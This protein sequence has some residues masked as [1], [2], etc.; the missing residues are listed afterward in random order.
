ME[1]IYKKEGIQ[2]I[3]C[4]GYN[5]PIICQRTNDGNELLDSLCKIVDS[6]QM[7]NFWF[8][9]AKA[10]PEEDN[11]ADCEA[12]TFF[13]LKGKTIGKTKALKNIK[14]QIT[15]IDNTDKVTEIFKKTNT[16]IVEPSV[17]FT[18]GY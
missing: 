6:K 8:C 11:L 14:S 16:L 2:L 18:I 13:S 5:Y 1:K 15:I 12:Y 4:D 17:C 3:T 7:N 10:V 9:Y